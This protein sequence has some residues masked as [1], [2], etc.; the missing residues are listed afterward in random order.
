MGRCAGLDDFEGEAALELHAGGTK[1]GAQGTCGSTLLANHFSDIAS[2][3]MEAKDGRFLFGE[4]LYTDSTSVIHQRTGNFGQKEFHFRHSKATVQRVRCL[5][6]TYTSKG[7]REHTTH[8]G[9]LNSLVEE[10][11]RNT[12]CRWRTIGQK[13]FK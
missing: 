11:A 1:N 9:R 8:T 13:N 12:L 3:D 5:G 4:Y 6:H 2:S 10:V 7:Y